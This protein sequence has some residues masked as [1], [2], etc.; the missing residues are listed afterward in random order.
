MLL[1]GG[2]TLF[3]IAVHSHWE[4]LEDLQVDLVLRL[5]L[6]DAVDLG[7]DPFTVVIQVLSVE[8]AA[9]GIDRQLGNRRRTLQGESAV[10]DCGLSTHIL[11]ALKIRIVNA[12]RDIGS[13][14]SLLI[15]NTRRALRVMEVAARFPTVEV[16]GPRTPNE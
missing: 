6:L 2:Q 5:L 12:A 7:L 15:Q 9:E 16:S 10:V 11:R 1:V 14:Q 4:A 3:D 8:R 13:S